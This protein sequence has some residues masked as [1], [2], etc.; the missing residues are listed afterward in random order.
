[1]GVKPVQAQLIFRLVNNDS[2]TTTNVKITDF[3]LTAAPAGTTAPTQT[4]F[5]PEIRP[6]ATPNFNL[7][8]DV[9]NSLVPEYGRTSY[10]ADTKLLYRYFYSQY[11]HL[12]R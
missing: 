2:D 11:G 12:Q 4:T 1:M 5:A 8:T 3:A 7:L 10:N 9:S 6:G